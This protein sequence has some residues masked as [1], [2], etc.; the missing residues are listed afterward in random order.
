MILS[1]R[2]RSDFE[3]KLAGL[4]LE[5]DDI[6]D[7]TIFALEHGDGAEEVIELLTESIQQPQMPVFSKIAHLYLI[8][9]ILHNS[10]LPIQ[11]AWKYRS[12]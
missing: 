10:S 7:A 4:T 9:D 12:G 8:S 3:R 5:R 1:S 11:N 2:E 6:F